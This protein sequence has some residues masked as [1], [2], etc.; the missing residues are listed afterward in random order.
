MI[1]TLNQRSLDEVEA[2]VAE[3]RARGYRHFDVKLAPDP[4][5]HVELCRLVE[6]LAP[7]GLLRADADGGYD[8]ATALAAAPRLAEAGVAV[9]AARPGGLI[10]ARRRIEILK[11]EG[12]IFLGSGLTDPDVS[13]A[14]SLALFGACGL[15]RPAALNG[16][17]FLAESFLRRPLVPADGQ[18][19]VPGGPGLGVEVDEERVRRPRVGL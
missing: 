18:L 2:L 19:A 10:K 7:E 9:E 5:F 12:L 13:L 6:S 15:A 1:F 4:V 11:R 14:A 17:Q 16:P 3:G 8:E